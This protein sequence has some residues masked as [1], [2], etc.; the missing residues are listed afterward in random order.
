MLSNLQNTTLDLVLICML[1]LCTT[2]GKKP[3]FTH[4]CL[5]ILKF[6]FPLCYEGRSIPTILDCCKD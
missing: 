6:N 1:L 3:T 2:E 4:Q 5:Y